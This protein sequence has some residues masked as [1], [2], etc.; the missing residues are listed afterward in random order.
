MTR[1]R[2]RRGK[3]YSFAGIGSPFSSS[4]GRNDRHLDR[5]IGV[6]DLDLA[7]DLGERRRTL[8]VARLEDLDDAREAVRDVRTGDAARVERAHRQ[9]GARLTDRLRGDDADR[10]ADLADVPGREER[11]VTGAADAV[12]AL[13][14]EHRAHRDLVALGVLLEPVEQVLEERQRE[15]GPRLGEE[16]LARLA[17]LERLEHVDGEDP[18]GDA[19]VE[20]VVEDRRQLDVVGRAAV[21][22]T[23]DHVLRDVDEAP[24]QVA[25]VGGPQSRVGEALAGTVRRDEVLEHRQAFHEVGLDRALDDLALRIRHQAAHA[26][27]LADLVERSAGARVGHHEDR[28]RLVEVVLHRL[29]DF[30]RRLGPD[31]HDA[32]VPLLLGHQAAL[33]LALELRHLRLVADE[34]LFL[35]GRDHDVVLRD[36]DAGLGGVAERERLDR[37]EHRRNGVCAVAVDELRDER[38]DLALRERRG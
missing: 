36:R 15:L 13:A 38:V 4:D 22:I 29:R 11:A 6:L 35:V 25:R 12:L 21:E 3:L 23:D 27:E 33:V 18:P 5:A 10:V 8:R 20:L 1:N 37:V 26:G 31:R 19:R 2:V 9:L 17:V 28:V 16:R 34:D 7:A 14:L 30:L 24:G 32:L